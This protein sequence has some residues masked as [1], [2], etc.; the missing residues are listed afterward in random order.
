MAEE[1]ADKYDY[2]ADTTF[3]YVPGGGWIDWEFSKDK[4]LVDIVWDS[5]EVPGVPAFMKS[6]EDIVDAKLIKGWSNIEKLTTNQEML[7]TYKTTVDELND[8][9]AMVIAWVKADLRDYIRYLVAHGFES[10]REL[11]TILKYETGLDRHTYQLAKDYVKESY[12]DMTIAGVGGGGDEG[13][14]VDKLPTRSYESDTQR[15]SKEMDEVEEPE[16]PGL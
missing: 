6:K 7:A 4:P 14:N 10:M 2:L 11:M 5:N 15:I 1:F 16:E 12:K 8:E 3:K 9:P 13:I